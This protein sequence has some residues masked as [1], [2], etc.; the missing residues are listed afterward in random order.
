MTQDHVEGY[1]ELSA[2]TKAFFSTVVLEWDADFYMKVDDDVHVNLGQ[3]D[4][5]APPANLL[6][7]RSVAVM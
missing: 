6:H 3:P 7:L 4:S 2:K 1:H 5:S